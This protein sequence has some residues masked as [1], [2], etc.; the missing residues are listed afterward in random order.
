MLVVAVDPKAPDPRVVADAAARLR[1]GGLV[2][3][4]TETVYGLGALAL[5]REAVRRVYATKGRPATHP[6]IVHVLGEADA[7]PLAAAWPPLAR[8]L[9][10]A[11]WPG[12]L[13]LVV[14]KSDAVPGEIT[15]GSAAVAVRAPSHPVARALLAAVGAPVVAPS[16]NRYQSLSPTRA[17]HVAASLGDADVLVL[18]AGACPSG[19]ESTVVDAR[20]GRVL[21]PGALALDALRAVAP[22]VHYATI[23]APAGAARESPG[24]DPRHY[25]PRTP[26]AIAPDRASALAARAPGVAVVLFGEPAEGARALP[27]DP[28]AAGAALYALLH[29]LDRAGLARIVVE[30]PPA[31]PGWE[32]I[33]DRLRR[34]TAR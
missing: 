32:A 18:D 15:G 7:R 27:A 11:F 5:D 3:F 29:E 34:A 9:A 26:L 10:R 33:A 30:A 24:Q 6:L 16:A 21:R 8:D 23:D 31:A 22:S 12:P 2:A 20:D 4:P 28:A 1:A 13:T 17:E 19:I 25:A 14:A